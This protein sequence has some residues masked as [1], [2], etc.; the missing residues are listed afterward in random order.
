MATSDDGEDAAEQAIVYQSPTFR[1]AESAGRGFA[2]S[3]SP[4][5]SNPYQLVEG[6]RPVKAEVKLMVKTADVGKQAIEIR[7]IREFVDLPTCREQQSP[8]PFS[9][10]FQGGSNS[11]SPVPTSPPL[12]QRRLPSPPSSSKS[13]TTSPSSSPN[14]SPRVPERR[15]R[16]PRRLAGPHQ[17]GGPARGK[18][19]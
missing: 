16:K 18:M 10:I 15:H 11:S 6:G 13:S 12:I 1:F 8:G 2:P 9:R 3:S 19:D 5:P 4:T 7:S 17:T 14:A